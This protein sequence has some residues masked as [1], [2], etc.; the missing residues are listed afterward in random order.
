MKKLFIILVAVIITV[1]V[2]AQAPQLMSYQAS[3]K[4]C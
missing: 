4:K 3:N 1:S 2:F